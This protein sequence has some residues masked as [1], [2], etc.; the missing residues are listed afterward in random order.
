MR[1]NYAHQDAVFARFK[2]APFCGI[3]AETGTGKSRMGLQLLENHYKENRIT[4]TLLVTMS[5]LTGVW[6]WDNIP[7]DHTIPYDIFLWKKS[8][9]FPFPRKMLYFVINIDGVKAQDFREAYR[10]FQRLHPKF[11]LLIDESTIVKNEDSARTK[12]IQ[13]IADR[14]AVRIIMSGRSVVQGP[15]DLYS[16]AN[17]LQRELLGKSY[18]AYRGR[19]AVLKKQIIGKPYLDPDK[20]NPKIKARAVQMVVGYQRME[21]LS[22]RIAEWAVVIKKAD[23][24][25][26][27]PKTYKKV[28]VDLTPEQRHAYD[29]LLGRGWTYFK[30]H[31]ITAINSVALLNRLL[32]ICA[33]QMKVENGYVTIPTLKTQALLDLRERS[34]DDPMIVWS[35]FNEASRQAA[36]AIGNKGLAI[37]SGMAPAPLQAALNSFRDG[38]YNTLIA[39]QASLGH[40]I[41]LVNCSNTVYYSQSFNLEQRVQSEDRVHRIGQ[42]NPC[43]YT[44]IVVRKTVEGRV[45][46]RL[47]EKLE[48]SDLILD[49]ARF[50]DFIHSKDD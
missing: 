41:T 8:K 33:G 32:Q 47:K 17:I 6:V 5:A 19:Y 3:F 23:C 42:R 34:G 11:A 44:D 37:P 30:E 4:A 21:E 45:I 39:N 13:L 29:D 40:G 26:L 18:Y 43:L 24:L 35:Y 48:L 25:D 31:E 12:I 16:Q 1:K 38:S 10:T 7:D 28:Q 2:D 22:E 50:L 46:Q 20:Q 14:A 15:L 9:E 36:L 27:P 49:K